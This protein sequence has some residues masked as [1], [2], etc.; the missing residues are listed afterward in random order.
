MNLFREAENIVKSISRDFGKE[1]NQKFEMILNRNPHFQIISKIKNIL[2]F[3]GE[4]SEL[5]QVKNQNFAK[6]KFAP[7]TPCDIE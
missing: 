7:T 4:M 3:N 6:Y 2:Q 5:G 1:L